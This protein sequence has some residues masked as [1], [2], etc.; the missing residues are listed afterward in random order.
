MERTLSEMMT[1]AEAAELLKKSRQWVYIL[2]T[3]GRIGGERIGNNIL[4]DRKDVENF[5]LKRQPVK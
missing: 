5:K 4:L 1:V 2:F 3:Q